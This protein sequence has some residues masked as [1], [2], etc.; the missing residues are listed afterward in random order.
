MIQFCLSVST[1]L[2]D[3]L[4][5]CIHDW[6]GHHLPLLSSTE[7]T[8]LQSCWPQPAFL[9]SNRGKS[10]SQRVRDE[11]LMSSVQVEEA[12]D[13]AD[14]GIKSFL[15]QRGQRDKLGGT[16][17]QGRVVQK[18]SFTTYF[19]KFKDEPEVPGGGEGSAD[20]NY[21][22]ARSSPSVKENFPPVSVTSSLYCQLDKTEL[23]QK[24]TSRSMRVSRKF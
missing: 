10:L 5:L 9:I 11:R 21:R 6:S 17:V 16:S 13:R 8:G 18:S 23:L 7:T 2:H 15:T 24:Q 4:S 12:S 1:L 20:R 22:G 14:T 3:W 19:F